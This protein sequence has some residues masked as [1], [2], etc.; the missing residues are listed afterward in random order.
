M[1]KRWLCLCGIIGL[2]T[3][4]LGIEAYSQ[5]LDTVRMRF[6][7]KHQFQFAGYY[8]AIEKG[9]YR[10]VGLNVEVAERDPNKRA[11]KS[12][13][14]GEADYGVA[15]PEALLA[16]LKG[17][18]IVVLAVI[19]QHNPSITL[20]RADSDI[21]H[22]QDLIGKRLMT[23]QNA[24]GAANMAALLEEGVG[25]DKLTF[26]KPSWKLEDLIQKKV[27]ALA[28]YSTNEPFYLTQQGIGYRM[29]EPLNYGVD[30]YGDNLITSR[31]EIKNNPERV[32]GIRAASLKGWEYAMEH[33][34][35]IID[36]ILTK[37]KS[38][39][40]REHLEFE[41]E[42]MRRLVLPAL[43]EMGHMN[44]GRW[45]RIAETYAKLELIEPNYSLDGF[46]YDPNPEEDLSWLWWGMG[47]ALAVILVLG[48]MASMLL[49]FN[50]KLTRTVEERTRALRATNDELQ[51]AKIHAETANRAKSEFLAA[52]SHEI[53]TP[54]NAII[55]MAELLENSS[56][57]EEQRKRLEAV[58]RSG[59][60]LL[61]LINDI[62]DFS[63]I[64]ADQIEIEKIHFDLGELVERNLEMLALRAHQKGLELSF[65]FGADVPINLIGDP[66]RL[67]QILF[68]LIGNAVKFTPSGSVHLKIKNLDEQYPSNAV[69]SCRIRFEVQDSGIGIPPEKQQN[70]FQHFTQVDAST[71][72]RYGGT[73]LGLAICK[74]LV[75]LM[76]GTIGLSSEVGKGSVFFFE[77][78]FECERETGHYIPASPVDLKD[79][80]VLV[81]DDT[82]DNRIIL[83]EMLETW[84]AKVTTCSSGGQCL[85]ELYQAYQS[86]QP[87]ELLILD[88]RMP[89]LDGFTIVERIKT[90]P[91][92]SPMVL[93]I[94]SDNRAGDLQR[95][96]E[97]GITSYLVKPVKRDELS[98][99]LRLACGEQPGPL[100]AATRHP[101]RLPPLH[102]LLVEDSLDNRYIFEHQLKQFGATV[103]LADDGEKALER[104]R[105]DTYDLVLMDMQMPVMDGYTATRAIRQWEGHQQLS[106]VPI[107][108]LTAF[109]VKEDLQK[110]LD[111]GCNS[112]ITK[113]LKKATLFEGIT[114]FLIQS[115][116]LS[117]EDLETYDA[118][119]EQATNPDTTPDKYTAVIDSELKELVPM[120]LKSKRQQS[121]EVQK[122]VSQED[123]ESVRLLGHK[124]QG[125]HGIDALNHFGK[126]LGAAAK[127][128]DLPSLQKLSK[129][130]DDYLQKIK[131]QY[132]D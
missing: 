100:R 79:K 8:A 67:R 29:I 71:T 120:I 115:G 122:A 9:Y 108:A 41:A 23:F 73:G 95:C 17:D 92:I 3:M 13:V 66:T 46:L 89:L 10:E 19:F 34:Q 5:E 21:R 45:E 80:R 78:P 124:M 68:N 102:I 18:P 130:L 106:P 14:D 128:R 81:V 62:L 4:L 76:G 35:E 91:E 121:Q 113:P 126:A 83:K 98:E 30:F 12:V 48:W 2:C 61:E 70:I 90:M 50:K 129:E 47:G 38:P 33:P 123:F 86:K 82:E 56:L 85:D 49:F 118:P 6:K 75:E 31:N 96:R 94:T 65:H 32:A 51:E 15:G 103:D 109:S 110:C 116:K 39:K 58:S 55:G 111:A 88:V 52:M 57:D 132:E 27:D 77:L 117:I 25:F 107:I 104:F 1:L 64:E 99:A 114:S 20:V 37:Y 72:R 119:T 7:W 93:M 42:A 125:A 131:I 44:R 74:R 16:F 84:Q 112:Y 26:V 36:L 97:L 127:Q 60:T 101:H 63:K 59:D 69:P 11:F 40:K 54:L 105:Q 43:V 53:R 24:S 87:Y 22:P 28:A